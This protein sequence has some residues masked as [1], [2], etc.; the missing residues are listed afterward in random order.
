MRPAPVCARCREC[1]DL[2]CRCACHRARHPSSR[3]R[4]ERLAEVIDIGTIVRR[5]AEEDA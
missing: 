5:V 4:V 3:P 1:E 2:D